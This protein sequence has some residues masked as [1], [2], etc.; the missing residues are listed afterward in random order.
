M[1]TPT[2]A[3]SV[4]KRIVASVSSMATDS[5][6]SQ[7]S[8]SGLIWCRASAAAMRCGRS[9]RRSWCADR[10]MATRMRRPWSRQTRAWRQ[11]SSM[12][13]APSESI[14]PLRSAMGMK[15]LGLIMPRCGWCQRSSASAAVTCA[16]GAWIF[17]W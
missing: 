10:L 6:I 7:V 4:K 8:R 1:C 12:T 13:Q 17:G 3:S 5:V 11:A 2:A 9:G 15:T 14:R 16:L